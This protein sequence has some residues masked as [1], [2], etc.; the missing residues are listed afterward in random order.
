MVPA[1]VEKENISYITQLSLFTLALFSKEFYSI[2]EE[3]YICTVQ[4]IHVSERE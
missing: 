1:E 4:T 2:T 3:A